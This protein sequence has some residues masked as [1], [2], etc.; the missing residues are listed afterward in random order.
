MANSHIAKKLDKSKLI[1][2]YGLSRVTDWTKKELAEIQKNSKLPVCI[3]LQNGDYMVATYKIV[4]VSGILWTVDDLE[5]TDKRSAI[6]YC[7]MMHMA[8]ATEAKELYS[9]DVKVSRHESDKALFRVRLDS[10]HVANNQFKIDLYSSR[11]EEAKNSLKYAKQELEKIISKAKYNNS[12]LL[13][14]TKL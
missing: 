1:E 13:S 7:A 9:A 12:F 8:K 11:Y 6:F 2:S 3:A 4:K 5:F 10:A 14:G